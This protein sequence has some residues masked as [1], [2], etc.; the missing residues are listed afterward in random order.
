[1]KKIVFVFCIISLAAGSAAAQSKAKV[2]VWVDSEDPSAVMAAQPGGSLLPVAKAAVGNI[3]RLAV[4]GLRTDKANN[5]VDLG[6][7]TGENIELDVVVGQ[8]RRGYVASVSTT[9][10][11]VKDGPL[12]VSSNVIAAST[13]RLLAS[14]IALA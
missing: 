8:F 5:V 2:C 1:M 9:I 14:D 4:A 7:Q 12:H 11:G 3:Q 13:E 10:Q 6:P